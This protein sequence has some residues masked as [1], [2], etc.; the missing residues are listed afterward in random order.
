LHWPLSFSFYSPSASNIPLQSTTVEPYADLTETSTAACFAAVPK[1]T[2][3]G[4]DLHTPI[5]TFFLRVC[6]LFSLKKGTI[7]FEKTPY[8]LASTVAALEMHSLLPNLRVVALLR[9]PAARAYSSFYHHCSRNQRLV[10]DAKR[11]VVFNGDCATVEHCCCSPHD[12][13]PKGRL[14]RKR[15]AANQRQ[16]AGRTAGAATSGRGVAG[17]VAGLVPSWRSAGSGKSGVSSAAGRAAADAGFTLAHCDAE[18]FDNY[19]ASTERDAA[20][21]GLGTVLRKGLYGSQLGTY[22]RLFGQ[23]NVLAM[24]FKT[25]ARD[26]AAAT[27]RVYAFAGLTP[28]EFGPDRAAK[29][30]QGFWYLKGKESKS[31]KQKPYPPMLPSSKTMLG[32]FYKAPDAQLR[33]LFPDEPFTWMDAVPSVDAAADLAADAAADASA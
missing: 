15:V 1:W 7:T 28:Y 17:F 5:P 27:N 29:N 18:S 25:F 2:A 33:A 22:V 11:R 30:E 19:L 21:P 14:A 8:Y 23:A 16:R 6:F 12:V 13:K 26:P 24:D 3:N 10:V 32:A 9:D 4:A 31:N 20:S